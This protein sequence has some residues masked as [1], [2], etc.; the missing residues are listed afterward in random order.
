MLFVPLFAICL[1]QFVMAAP[2]YFLGLGDL[3]G[4]NFRSEANAISSDGTIVVGRSRTGPNPSEDEAFR[5]TRET[6]MVSL[7]TIGKTSNAIAISADGTTIVGITGENNI[8]T[9]PVN[10]RAFR[11]TQQSG[12]ELLPFPPDSAYAFASDVT[13]DGNVIVG[14]A[15][16][17]GIRWTA[18]NFEDL[19]PILGF[20][21]SSVTAISHD[22]STFAGR[23]TTG[24]AV[25]GYVW[26]EATGTRVITPPSPLDWAPFTPE[27]MS[28]DGA[29]VVGG[30]DGDR[31][32][33]M[34]SEPTGAVLLGLTPDGQ[35]PRAANDV[36]DDGLVIVG[37][38]YNGPFIWDSLH[39]TR[40]LEQL[41]ISDYGLAES[42]GGWDLTAA[43]AISADKRTIVGYGRNPSG[44]TEAWIAFLGTPTSGDFDDDGDVD[45][46][47]FLVW[48][49]TPGVGSFADWRANYGTMA[50]ASVGVPEPA[51]GAVL[52]VGLYAMHLRRPV[53]RRV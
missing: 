11:W 39:G 41:L 10:S 28:A 30:A 33:L 44:R 36:S 53:V 49:R 52:L 42:L 47:D 48:Q 8:F 29:V 12:M 27:A 43:T 1:Q 31:G 46:N 21:N 5:W 51:S 37:A 45:G 24:S 22:G 3:P 34:W 23:I 50:A 4:G 25:L 15:Q 16:E 17:P 6:G 2:A 19:S 40:D 32:A 38:T 9:D 14:R 26:T 13:S 20:N 18:T 7:G 35:Y